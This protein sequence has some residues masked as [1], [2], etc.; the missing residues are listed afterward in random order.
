M[1]KRIVLLQLTFYQ[2]FFF[3][4][5]KKNF[6]K[7]NQSISFYPPHFLA[8]VSSNGL[9]QGFSTFKYLRTPK[10]K[11]TSSAYPQTMIVPLCVLPNS[12]FHLNVH[13]L[14]TFLILDTNFDLPVYPLWTACVPLG[15]RTPGWES[16]FYVNQKLFY[17]YS[18][19]VLPKYSTDAICF[20]R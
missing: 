18:L 14:D 9:C 1:H 5:K 13:V 3:C 10:S 4:W 6:S 12:E 20:S 16:L 7:N 17:H 11:F 8:S 19:T 15:T 2:H